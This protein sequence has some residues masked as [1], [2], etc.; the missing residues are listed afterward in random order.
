MALLV[1]FF[2]L[3]LLFVLHVVKFL[4]AGVVASPLRCIALPILCIHTYNS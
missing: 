1:F 3:F 2:F 4:M